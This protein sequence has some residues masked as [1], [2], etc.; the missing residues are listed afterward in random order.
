MP[1][2]SLDLTS[3]YG[4]HKKS[5]CTTHSKMN[6]GCHKL[7]QTATLSQDILQKAM[8]SILFFYQTNVLWVKQVTLHCFQEKGH[9]CFHIQFPQSCEY[10]DIT[11]LSLV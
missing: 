1:P 9:L 10:F 5:V 11:V 8:S 4:V 7:R 2:Q 6:Q 3:F